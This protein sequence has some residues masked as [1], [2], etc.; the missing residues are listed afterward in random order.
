MM[1]WYG[2]VGLLSRQSRKRGEG[3]EDELGATIAADH[4]ERICLRSPRTA[5]SETMHT[6]S[7][8]YSPLYETD[9]FSFRILTK[10]AVAP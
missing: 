1:T 5:R 6:L 8:G 9:S 4:K 2:R 3:K 7:L 10:Q